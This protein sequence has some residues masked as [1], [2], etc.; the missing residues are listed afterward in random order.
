[1][2]SPLEKGSMRSVLMWG[3]N[4]EHEDPQPF[5]REENARSIERLLTFETPP[6]IRRALRWYRLG[7]DFD[8]PDDQFTYFWFA[9]ETVAEYQ[10]SNAKVHDKCPHCQSP[11]Y[12]ETCRD[13]PVHKPYAKQAIRD[14]LKAAD[15]EFDDATFG[16]LDGTRNSLMHGSTLKEIEKSLPDPHDKI[17]DTLGRLLWRALIIQ[18]PRELFDGTLVMGAPS[19]YLHYTAHG[20]VHLKTVVPLDSAGDLDLSFEGMNVS[21]VPQ[22]P[23]QSALP[24]LISMTPEQYERLGVLSYSNGE[25]EGMLQRIYQGVQKM[26]GLVFVL[27]LATD[28]ALIESALVR[29][30][31][32]P[33]QDLFREIKAQAK[34]C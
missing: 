21:M 1:M 22:G 18:F 13:H 31:V 4:V 14:L 24:R 7:V 16:L 23:P 20:V 11:L 30:E 25:Q 2:R 28:M 3:D 33:W 26:D 27:V 32:G 29:G 12:C 5:L 6:A 19:T 8:V 10:K 34:K 9:L 15:Q 17:V